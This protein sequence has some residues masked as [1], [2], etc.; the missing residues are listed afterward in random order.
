MS[1]A[2]SLTELGERIRWENIG[3]PIKKG[4]HVPPWITDILI[5]LMKENLSYSYSPSMGVTSTR[6]WLA[7]RGNRIYDLTLTCEDICFFNGVSDAA[8]CLYRCLPANARIIVP[9]PSYSIHPLLES[10]R[11]RRK[12]LTFALDPENKWYP[13]L[14]DLEYQLATKK[15]IVGILIVNPDNPTGMVYPRN[16]L[17]DIVALARKH[18]VFIVA[19]EIYRNVVFSDANC[20]PLADVIEDV[21]GMSLQGISKNIPWPGAR[22]GWIE[23]YNRNHNVEFSRFCETLIKA[24]LFEVSSTTL[25]QLAIPKIFGDPRFESYRISVNRKIENTRN[26]VCDLLSDIP[27]IQIIRPGGAFYCTVRF[28]EGVLNDTQKIAVKNEGVKHIL[29]SWLS[30][31]IRKDHRFVYNLLASTGICTVPLTSF[32]TNQLGF[33]MTLLESQELEL[34]RLCNDLKLAIWEYVHS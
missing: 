15:N 19:D 20:Y 5:E 1:R 16:V 2:Q 29:K 8:A 3:D 4:Y 9:S 26:I 27:E 30:K 10:T 12:P 6:E 28:R 31:P 23:F 24:K 21:P 13:A 17:S 32:F 34:M 33:R 11:A 7:D 22:C 25:P 14:D 18:N